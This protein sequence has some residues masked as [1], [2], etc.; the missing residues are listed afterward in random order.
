MIV[1]GRINVAALESLASAFEPGWSLAPTTF[2]A[3]DMHHPAAPY[4][5]VRPAPPRWH[6]ESPNRPPSPPAPV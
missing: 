4:S 5:A 1:P 6:G 3:V 2:A